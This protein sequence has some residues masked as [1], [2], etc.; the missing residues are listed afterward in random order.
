MNN[1]KPAGPQMLNQPQ[2]PAYLQMP[3][4]MNT[5]KNAFGAINQGYKMN[6]RSLVVMNALP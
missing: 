2:R 6:P 3:I 4:Q 5:Y 1:L